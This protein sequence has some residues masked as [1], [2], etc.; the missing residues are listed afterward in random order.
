MYTLG[1]PMQPALHVQQLEREAVLHTS[2]Y[3]V[4]GV[5]MLIHF[6]FPELVC[7]PGL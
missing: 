3:S 5:D 7:L 1:S 6:A 2:Q 4:S